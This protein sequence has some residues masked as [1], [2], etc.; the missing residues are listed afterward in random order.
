MVE[1]QMLEQIDAHSRQ[2][3][4][5]SPFCRAQNFNFIIIIFPGCHPR[6]SCPWHGWEGRHIPTGIVCTHALAHTHTKSTVKSQTC[7]TPTLFLERQN[8]V[9]KNSNAYTH[10][11][12]IKT[13]AE[14]G[15]NKTH[16]D[17]N[18]ILHTSSSTSDAGCVDRNRNRRFESLPLS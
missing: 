4:R 6:R 11:S 3:N 1:S 18:P 14:T 10:I 9:Y 13:E 5:S 8:I 15:Q 16:A 7:S 2:W 17:M 12:L